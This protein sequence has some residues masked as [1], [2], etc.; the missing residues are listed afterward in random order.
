[1][2]TLEL[3]P[4]GLEG[5][6]LDTVLDDIVDPSTELPSPHGIKHGTGR[7]A[8]VLGDRDGDVLDRGGVEDRG[9]LVEA[10]EVPGQRL[11]F[12]FVAAVEGTMTWREAEELVKL[13]SRQYAKR[14][15][16][17]FRR[18][19][20]THWLLWEKNPDFGSARQRSTELL[21]EFGLG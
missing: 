6:Q 16:T 9:E 2:T 10:V 3:R 21:R 18:A 11:R 19:P 14:Q 12:E 4:G 8:G 5:P 20:E 1:M 7:G 17:W 15:L 13:R